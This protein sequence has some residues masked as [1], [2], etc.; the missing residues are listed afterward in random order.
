MVP[1][2]VPYLEEASWDAAHAHPW[3]HQQVG[4]LGWIRLSVTPNLCSTHLVAFGGAN[5]LHKIKLL[6]IGMFFLIFNFF[7]T[8][9]V[10]GYQKMGANKFGIL[11]GKTAVI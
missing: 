1:L 4:D 6:C 5:H 10:S 2:H 8:I 3:L 7:F 9:N 11:F